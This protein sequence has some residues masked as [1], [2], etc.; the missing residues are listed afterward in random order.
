M[1]LYLRYVK[2]TLKPHPSIRYQ[3]GMAM[4]K[5]GGEWIDYEKEAEMQREKIR[6]Y[7]ESLLELPEDMQKKEE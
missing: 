3:N 7:R 4:P 2:M 1:T 6:K 5:D